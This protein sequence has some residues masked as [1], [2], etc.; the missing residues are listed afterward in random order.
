[1]QKKIKKIHKNSKI[2]EIKPDIKFFFIGGNGQVSE[3]FPA[4][5]FFST[6]T[7]SLQ[8]PVIPV[9]P[10]KTRFLTI[11]R[12]TFFSVCLFPRKCCNICCK[13]VAVNYKYA[14][15]LPKKFLGPYDQQKKFQIKELGGGN[16][17]WGIPPPRTHRSKIF[18][19]GRMDLKIF[20]GGLGHICSSQKNFCNKCCNFSW[21][22]DKLKK[23]PK[24][25]PFSRHLRSKAL[26]T[27]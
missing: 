12:A 23:L 17:P 8:N 3:V 15:V 10:E 18:S 9:I 22:T 26:L 4:E 11:F 1:M 7:Q 14:R 20:F 5:K 6:P 25:T 19:I 2:G 21:E 16:P 13:N 24:K 27:F